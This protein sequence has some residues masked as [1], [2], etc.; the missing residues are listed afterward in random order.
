MKTARKIRRRIL[1]KTRPRETKRNLG[2]YQTRT[3]EKESFTSSRMKKKNWDKCLASVFPNEGS[4]ST[5]AITKIS[6]C[7]MRKNIRKRKLVY[8]DKAR[9]RFNFRKETPFKDKNSGD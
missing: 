9:I 3:A 4:V 2:R 8:E 5:A 1:V 6:T 7:R